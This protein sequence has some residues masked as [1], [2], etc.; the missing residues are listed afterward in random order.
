MDS[1]ERHHLFVEK[2]IKNIKLLEAHYNVQETC[3]KPKYSPKQTNCKGIQT[4]EDFSDLFFLKERNKSFYEKIGEVEKL[5]SNDDIDFSKFT[6]DPPNQLVGYDV[7][8]DDASDLDD[9]DSNKGKVELPTRRNKG[10]YTTYSKGFNTFEDGPKSP[11]YYKSSLISE[12]TIR[13]S[14]KRKSEVVLI[15]PAKFRKTTLN[16][17]KGRVPM[18][19][20]KVNYSLYDTESDAYCYVP[21]DS[22]N[23]A[24]KEE[25]TLSAE[26]LTGL[27]Q[28]CLLCEGRFGSYD[29]FV[30][31]MMDIH[32]I[33][34]QQILGSEV[35]DEKKKKLPDLLK[36]TDMKPKEVTG[37][38][39]YYNVII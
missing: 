25:N 9:D 17:R 1:I 32:G 6:V 34:M 14:F 10:P 36:I 33:D 35:L 12:I 28:I 7:E 30:G 38:K 23:I 11:Q 20:E 27:P 29:E 15:P 4:E 26:A 13:K 8:S 31:H 3:L 5:L 22:Q 2:C 19:V 24:I 39:K 16:K 21:N 37:K 18:K